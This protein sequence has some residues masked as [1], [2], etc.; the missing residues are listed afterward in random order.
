M[1]AGL[2][3][4][5]QIVEHE[6]R[7]LV[8]RRGL[9]PGN[10]DAVAVRRLIDEVVADYAERSLVAS[11]PP[12]VDAGQVAKTVADRV[13]GM[14]P[15]QPFFDDPD[16]EEIWIN[17][18]GKVFVAKAGRSRLTTTVLGE[19]QVHDLVELIRRGPRHHPPALGGQHPAAHTVHTAHYARTTRAAGGAAPAAGGSAPP[20][21]RRR[22]PGPRRRT[23]R[24]AP[25]AS[26]WVA[27]SSPWP[28][29]SPW[30]L[31]RQRHPP[32]PMG[33]GSRSGRDPGWP[34][35]WQGPPSPEDAY[36]AVDLMVLEAVRE[37]AWLA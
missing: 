32:Y 2:Q 24:P 28:P 15:L 1:S 23:W 25:C 13:V 19:E 20:A 10:G 37:L 33:S 22:T 31:L 3:T 18:P 35:P 11:M 34:V 21:S 12:L 8:R 5:D 36:V 14:A 9:D 16:V 29:C 17:E 30:A 27:W 4:A 26:S 6:V 7:E